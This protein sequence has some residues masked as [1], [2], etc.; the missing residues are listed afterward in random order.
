MKISIISASHRLNS[1]SKKIS[2]MLLKNLSNRNSKVDTYILDLAESPL[3]LW[4]PEKKN[5]KGIWGKTWNSISDNLKKSDGFILV[6]PEYGGM[7]TPAAK[8]LFL[9]CGNGEF[10]HKPGLIVSISSGNGGAYPIAELRL[11]SYKNT[12]IMWIPENIIIRNVE[13][14]NP[15]SHGKNIPDWLDNRIDYGLNLLL[16]Y[17]SNMKP[18]RTIINRKD[19]GNGM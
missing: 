4:S 9:L 6:V 14:F 7:A 11:S 18:L 19:F 8:N 13:E 2:F 3:P 5:G 17:A 10:S 1:Q 16:A 12:H 15:G